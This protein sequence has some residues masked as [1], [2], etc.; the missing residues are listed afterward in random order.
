MN[1]EVA[2][3][4]V[5]TQQIIAAVNALGLPHTCV[6]LT[7]TQLGWLKLEKLK[8]TTFGD[9]GKQELS[10]QGTLAD[11][12][13]DKDLASVQGKIK[14]AKETYSVLK[15][16][17]LQFTR[18]IDEKLVKPSMD[19]ENRSEA[20]IAVASAH[21]LDLRKLA[22]AAAASTN[23]KAN[24]LAALKAH[25]QNEYTRI[26]TTY[27]LDLK[28]H[29]TD[30]YTT[31]LNGDYTPDAIPDYLKKV[32]GFM[33]EVKLIPFTK[34]RKRDYVTDEEAYTAFASI[35]EYNPENDF[36]EALKALDDQFALYAEDS[37]NKAAA[38]AAAAEQLASQTKAAIQE[39][40]V[41]Q[42]TNT[43]I[44]NATVAQVDAPKI[45]KDL[46]IVV[47]NT[48]TWA[49]AVMSHFIKRFL[50]AA[51]KLR[52]KQWQKLSIGQ[53]ADALAKLSE[54]TNEKYEGLTIKEVEK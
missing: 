50:D 33:A 32:K 11:I 29:I 9:L 49:M 43:L 25:I 18:M 48:Q 28:K 52:V 23:A 6:E 51:P 21:E 12:V 13:G 24:E 22:S 15:D 8:G 39:Q 4:G 42:A 20:L 5:I 3:T 41:A 53:M 47:E 36:N 35:L 19:F 40:E 2:K 44:A 37:Q 38:A 45:K 14:T 27:K 30:A 26:A 1:T 16:Q 10:I 34:F 17:R 31:A 7:P 46:E 54:T